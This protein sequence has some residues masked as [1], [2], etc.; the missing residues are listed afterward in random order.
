MRDAV[1]Q[2]LGIELEYYI[3]RNANSFLMDIQG[4]AASAERVILFKRKRD[5]G[6]RVHPCYECTTRWL[7]GAGNCLEVDTDISATALIEKCQAVISMPFT[8]TA[9]I[10]REQGKPSVYYDPHGICEKDDRAAHGIPILSGKSELK[11]WLSSLP[12]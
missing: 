5:V 10:G 2:P 3:P 1:Y 12:A 9:L 8:S 4:A 6:T 11:E 7:S